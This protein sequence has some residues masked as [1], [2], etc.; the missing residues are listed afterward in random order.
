MRLQAGVGG[1]DGGAA[2][3][4]RQDATH[5]TVGSAFLHASTQ[6]VVTSAMPELLRIWLPTRQRRRP[7]AERRA[8]VVLLLQSACL[9]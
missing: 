6:S 5:T 2:G 9:G 3:N 4:G 8:A 7:S 1:G